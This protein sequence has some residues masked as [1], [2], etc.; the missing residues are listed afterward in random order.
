MRGF[1]SAL[2]SSTLITA[3][4]ID[5]NYAK[6]YE[7]RTHSNGATFNFLVKKGQGIDAHNSVMLNGDSVALNQSSIRGRFTVQM[8]KQTDSNNYLR[9]DGTD[10]QTAYFFLINRCWHTDVGV[11]YAGSTR[12]PYEKFTRTLTVAEVDYYEAAKA[13]LSYPA[14]FDVDRF[15]AFCAGDVFTRD[16]AEYNALLNGPHIWG[17]Y[18]KKENTNPTFGQ[19]TYTEVSSR[20]YYRGGGGGGFGGFGNYGGGGGFGHT[21]GSSSWAPASSSFRQTT[22]AQQEKFIQQCGGGGNSFSMAAAPASFRNVFSGVGSSGGHSSLASVAASQIPE[23]VR[24]T[25]SVDVGMGSRAGDMTTFANLSL[26]SQTESWTT[27]A[28]YSSGV[29]GRNVGLS[30]AYSGSGDNASILRAAHALTGAGIMQL[31]AR[32][33]RMYMDATME[34]SMTNAMFGTL[35]RPYYSA[36]ILLDAIDRSASEYL[37]KRA[38]EEAVAKAEGEGKSVAATGGD[39]EDP[40][41]DDERDLLHNDLCNQEQMSQPGKITHTSS[42]QNG[43]DIF[44]NAENY[45]K[46]YGGDVADYVKKTSTSRTLANGEKC[47]VH[48]VENLK[49]GERYNF[50]TKFPKGL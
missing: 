7:V 40:G 47:E 29:S 50:K 9:T 45:A 8:Y 16:D 12:D 34:E 4:K 3:P 5:L 15:I 42:G 32:Q 26:C 37:K 39:G 35:L 19:I 46:D 49:T 31:T 41:S 20:D 10:I 11:T 14:Y 6:G 43:T 33:G 13:P 17:T 23:G 21:V 24:I 1:L 44:K 27:S 25:S 48:W 2:R 38:D 18:G 30:S 36:K 22:V 28:S